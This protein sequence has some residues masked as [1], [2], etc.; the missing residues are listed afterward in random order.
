LGEDELEKKLNKIFFGKEEQ[1]E[2]DYDI[3]KTVEEVFDTFT[4]RSL[5]DLSRKVGLRKISGVISAGKEARVYRGVDNSGRELAIKIYLTFSAEFKKGIYKYIEGDVRFE[6]VKITGTR[7]LMSIWAR[8]EYSNLK[9]MFSAGVRVPEP[10]AQ[11]D[12]IVVMEFIGKNG[13]RAP[14]LKEIGDA[15]RNPAEI[16]SEIQENIRKMVCS[17]RLVHADLSEYNI[18]VFDDSPVIIDVSQSVLLSHPN[19]EE[20]LRKDVSN[21]DRFFN[22]TYGI[23][24]HGDTLLEELMQCLR[25]SEGSI[26]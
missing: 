12:N 22:R 4:L 15:L 20:F 2:K 9:K 25:K 7:R 23:E 14:L 1:R 8:K 19:A 10:L 5:F 17:A 3:L 16:Y 21:I 11:K 6:R 13:V 26:P 24:V 18:M